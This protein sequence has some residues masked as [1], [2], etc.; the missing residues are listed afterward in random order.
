[1]FLFLRISG[2]WPTF[3]R[4]PALRSSDVGLLMSFGA[5]RMVAKRGLELGQSLDERGALG[6]AHK[7]L[8]GRRADWVPAR[9][10]RVTVFEKGRSLGKKLG[11]KKDHGGSSSGEGRFLYKAKRRSTRSGGALSRVGDELVAEGATSVAVG[12]EV[13]LEA[14]GV[15][16]LC[17]AA[18]CSGVV[19]GVTKGV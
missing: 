8:K 4:S 17:G 13:E 11:R 15:D 7:D 9:V 16:A 14:V 12:S 6:M 2:R 1:M 18:A 10:A 5:S 3:F 19:L